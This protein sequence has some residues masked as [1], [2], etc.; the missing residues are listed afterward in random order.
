M[1]P[2]RAWCSRPRQSTP[3]SWAHV[4]ILGRLR[5]HLLQALGA[6]MAGRRLPLSVLRWI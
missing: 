4:A 6:Q 1:V 3:C 5:S 2:A